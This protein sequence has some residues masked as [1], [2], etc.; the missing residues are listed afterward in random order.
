MEEWGRLA[1][2]R[3]LQESFIDSIKNSLGALR[4]WESL[5]STLL[6]LEI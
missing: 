2:V 3:D 5:Q 4:L 1:G 6:M